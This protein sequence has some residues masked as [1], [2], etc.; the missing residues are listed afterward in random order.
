MRYEGLKFETIRKLRIDGGYNTGR[1]QT[2]C[3]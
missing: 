3:T 2:I 1:S